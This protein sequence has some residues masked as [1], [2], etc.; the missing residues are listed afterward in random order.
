MHY[1]RTAVKRASG[2]RPLFWSQGFCFNGS[3]CLNTDLL[4]EPR[5]PCLS[6]H[7]ACLSELLGGPEE[8][9]AMKARVD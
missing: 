3:K 2:A 7:P 9:S 5:F 1:A 4:S 6:D 8:L